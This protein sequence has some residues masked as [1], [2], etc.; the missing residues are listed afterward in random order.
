MIPVIGKTYLLDGLLVLCTMVCQNDG[1]LTVG[2]HVDGCEKIFNM[3]E[4]GD[5]LFIENNLKNIE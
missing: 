2:L 4:D 5:R 1:V 3:S